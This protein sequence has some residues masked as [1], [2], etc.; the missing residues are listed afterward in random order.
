MSA[1]HNQTTE[2]LFNDSL[3]TA[4]CQYAL[5]IANDLALYKK[6]GMYISDNYIYRPISLLSCFDNIFEQ[7]LWSRLIFIIEKKT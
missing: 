7:I 2:N 4:K 3:E 1:L 5:E 6:N